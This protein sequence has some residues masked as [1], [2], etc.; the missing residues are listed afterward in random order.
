MTTSC[1]NIPYLEQPGIGTFIC[2]LAVVSWMDTCTHLC[3]SQPPFWLWFYL[4]SSSLVSMLLY[5]C[6]LSSGR[7]FFME[8]MCCLWQLSYSLSVDITVHYLPLA[9][10]MSIR[11][12]SIHVLRLTWTQLHFV[13]KPHSH[14]LCPGKCPLAE[15]CTLGTQYMEWKYSWPCTFS[16]IIFWFHTWK[17]LMNIYVAPCTAWMS[18]VGQQEDKVLIPPPPRWVSAQSY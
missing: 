5:L 15:F 11:I 6:L 2:L 7:G 12:V 8:L 10:L 3:P 14:I 9:F 13:Q 1:T 16:N 17:N 4:G 18:N